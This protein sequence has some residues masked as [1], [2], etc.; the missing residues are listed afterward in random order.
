MTSI[1]RTFRK[2]PAFIISLAAIFTLVTSC[3]STP[4]SAQPGRFAPSAQ[5]SVCQDQSSE[6]QDMPGVQI[7]QHETDF[8]SRQQTAQAQQ[9]Q[10]PQQSPQSQQPQQ[11]QQSQMSSSPSES[12]FRGIIGQPDN[13]GGNAGPSGSFGST[14]SSVSYVRSSLY[15]FVETTSDVSDTVIA[16]VMDKYDD[17][18]SAITDSFV[19]D[20]WTLCI[21]SENMAVTKL[22][23]SIQ[24]QNAIVCGLTDSSAKTI[25][26]LADS[27]GVGAVY[28]EFGHYIDWKTG[29]TSKGSSFAA[30]YSA[31][32][33]GL[34]SY[35]T[36]SATEFFAEVYSYIMSD[37]ATV[38]S[39]C[40]DAYSYVKSMADSITE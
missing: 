7:R 4:V 26:I 17:I 40:P 18:P 6:M 39:K 14:S 20:G 15:S 33:S 5:P 25:Y 12:S 29:Y 3:M 13:M 27:D 1:L 9:P 38:A 23:G 2:A 21:T 36:T 10:Q 31:E 28:H 24:Y 30:I 35:G 34:T 32:A 11:S 16:E 8:Q 19:N 37:P 22:S